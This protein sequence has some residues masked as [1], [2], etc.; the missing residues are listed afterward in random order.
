[1][2]VL[3]IVITKKYCYSVL[4]LIKIIIMFQ[5]FLL[6]RKGN[7]SYTSA[8]SHIQLQSTGTSVEM[9]TRQGK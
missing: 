2:V 5:I 3:A 7:K 8:T 9:E 6:R 4:E 1:M